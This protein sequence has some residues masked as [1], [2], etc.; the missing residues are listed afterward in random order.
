MF[1]AHGY[2]KSRTLPQ[3]RNLSD[4][5]G[6]QSHTVKRRQLWEVLV[7]V[8]VAFA[9]NGLDV[10]FGTVAFVQFVQDFHVFIDDFPNGCDV[11]GIELVVVLH[12]EEKLIGPGIALHLHERQRALLVVCP[13]QVILDGVRNQTWLR[14]Q[15]E[16]GNAWCHM[17]GCAVFQVPQLHELLEATNATRGPVW[18]QPDLDLLTAATLTSKVHLKDSVLL[19]AGLKQASLGSLRHQSSSHCRSK[20]STAACR[21]EAWG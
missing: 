14:R 10:G 4:L 11:L 3:K 9:L 1:T 17:V 20:C 2:R 7:Q 16:A 5:L 12:V 13:A 19:R 8:V 21:G 18:A 15:A 6:P